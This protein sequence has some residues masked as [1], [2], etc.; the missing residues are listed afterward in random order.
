M[1]PYIRHNAKVSDPHL[2]KRK[3]IRGG[4][5]KD[6]GYY[7]QTS[8]RTYEYQDTAKSYIGFRCVIDL[9]PTLVGRK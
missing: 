2:M 4:S 1:K 9:P 8:T 5:W 3:V 6:V 7:L